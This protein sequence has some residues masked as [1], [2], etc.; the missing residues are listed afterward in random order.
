MN[1]STSGQGQMACVV[2]LKVLIGDV[3]LVIFVLFFLFCAFFERSLLNLD[4]VF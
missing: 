2:Y 4:I 1:V 3:F